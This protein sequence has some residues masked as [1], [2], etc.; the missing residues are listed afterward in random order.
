[1]IFLDRLPRVKML[2]GGNVGLAIILSVLT[3]LTSHSQKTG[4]SA[5]GAAGIAM[6]FLYSIVY[7]ATYG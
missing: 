1:M 6:L 3:G 2:W 4:N 7:S 5:A